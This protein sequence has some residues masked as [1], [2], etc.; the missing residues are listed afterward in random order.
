MKRAKKI[1]RDEYDIRTL[2]YYQMQGG[3]YNELITYLTQLRS[4]PEHRGM[5]SP[6]V[7]LNEACFHRDRMASME[8]ED[9]NAYLQ[10]IDSAIVRELIQQMSSDKKTVSEAE[11]LDVQNHISELETELSRKCAELDEAL[12]Y[13]QELKTQLDFKP[14]D[15]QPGSFDDLLTLEN[16][17]QYIRMRH[18]YNQVSQLFLFLKDRMMDGRTLVTDEQYAAVK[19]T[20]QEML[21]QKEVDQTILNTNYSFGSQVFQGVLENP[22]FKELMAQWPIG[23]DPKELA[24]ELI[25]KILTDGRGKEN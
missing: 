24:Q 10:S 13:I 18:H 21:S 12:A 3:I 4:K 23:H 14:V 20:E 2:S 5:P 15:K 9:K 8:E 19:Q 17:L 7:L 11:L 22:Q 1:N 16:I 25:T 6:A